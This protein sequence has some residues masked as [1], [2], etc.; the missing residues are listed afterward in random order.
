MNENETSQISSLCVKENFV[1]SKF[2]SDIYRA[3]F[4]L[5]GEKKLW[6]IERI[7][8]PFSPEKEKAYKLRFGI[9]D[10]EMQTVYKKLRLAVSQHL[11]MNQSIL[12]KAK[13]QRKV[14]TEAGNGKSAEKEYKRLT[15]CTTFY[16]H[17]ELFSI[18]DLLEIFVVNEPGEALINSVRFGEYTYLSNI[19][20]LGIRLIQTAREYNTLGFHVGAFNLEEIVFCTVEEE[21]KDKVMVERTLTRNESFHTLCASGATMNSRLLAPNFTVHMKPEIAAGTE[22]ASLS[23]DIYSVCSIMWSLLDGRY[24]TEA[25]ALEMVPMYSSNEL[26]ECMTFGLMEGEAKLSE[27]LNT[28]HKLRKSFDEKPELD[29]KVPIRKPEYIIELE[30]RKAADEAARQ[31]EEAEAAKVVAENDEKAEQTKKKKPSSRKLALLAGIGLLAVMSFSSMLPSIGKHDAPTET[32]AVIE[33][34]EE[35]PEETPEPSATPIPTVLPD[36]TSKEAGIYR[37]GDSIVDEDGNTLENYHLDADGNILNAADKVII[38]S[39]MVETY[40][41]ISTIRLSKTT[42]DMQLVPQD[43]NTDRGIITTSVS[44]GPATATSSM[45]NLQ[46]SGNGEVSFPYMLN[47]SIISDRFIKAVEDKMKNM[48]DANENSIGLNAIEI[49]LSKSERRN[50]GEIYIYGYSE[51]LYDMTASDC[52]N[53]MSKTSVI[54]VYKA[55]IPTATPSPQPTPKPTQQQTQQQSSS[56]A[57]TSSGS[58]S[59]NIGSNIGGNSPSTTPQPTD[60][61]LPLVTPVPHYS[62]PVGIFFIVDGEFLQ[63]VN[64]TLHVGDTY[65]VYPSESCTWGCSDPN[66]ASID[67]SGFIRAYNPGSCT[68]TAYSANGYATINITVI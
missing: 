28:L 1:R 63:T 29:K 8:I 61:P 24:Y 60:T 3:E 16:V 25:P 50:V 17:R 58:I 51:G 23:G 35:I 19:I 7:A 44:I 39:E 11:K 49:D 13:E 57:G 40:I 30:K 4:T 5:N 59:S 22:P 66:I 10:E 6:D 14:N 54:N 36:T 65:P 45:L 26:T 34:T 42:Y 46:L 53:R 68:I 38:Q 41:Y 20:T 31:I 9:S 62:E 12:A 33:E 55:I 21:N 47:K 56:G 48:D 15:D 27:I 43:N 18:G 32:P 37:V 67:P 64:I 2:Y 52:A